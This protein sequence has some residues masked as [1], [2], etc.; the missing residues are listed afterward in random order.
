MLGRWHTTQ[1]SRYLDEM[2]FSAGLQLARVSLDNI[3]TTLNKILKYYFF[4]AYSI[5]LQGVAL[6]CLMSVVAWSTPHAR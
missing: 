6:K 2:E 1:E 4:L 3:F 5:A